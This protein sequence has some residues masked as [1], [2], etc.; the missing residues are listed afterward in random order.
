MTLLWTIA[1]NRSCRSYTEKSDSRLGW[2]RVH[3]WEDARDVF[4]RFLDHDANAEA[5][6]RL[7]E[8]NDAL[9][10]WGDCQRSDCQVR[11]L[12]D[13]NHND[14]SHTCITH[15]DGRHLLFFN[16]FVVKLL[17]IT[18]K[19]KEEIWAKAHETRESL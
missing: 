2:E 15:S 8:V 1:K 18:H 11:F 12:S 3:E 6:E 9:A 13:D 4:G 16:Y 17:H 19:C 10:S 7:A 14:D 5:H